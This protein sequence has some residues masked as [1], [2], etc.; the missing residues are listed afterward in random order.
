MSDCAAVAD[1]NVSSFCK[2]YG[3]RRRGRR[4]SGPD[5]ECGYAEGQAFPALVDAVHEKLISE[6]EI[7][8]AL[9]RL[10]NARLRLGMFDPPSSYAFGRIGM[11]ENNTP[12][13]RQLSLKASRESMVLLKNDKGVLP[14]KSSVANIAVIGPTAELVQSLQG[15]YNGPPPNPVYP[16]NGIEKRFKSAHVAYAMG[17]SLGAKGSRCRL[18]TR[19][20]TPRTAA[21]SLVLKANTSRQRT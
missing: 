8:Q 2:G 6:A 21:A 4:Q 11:E 20:C 1:I 9:R 14:L 15:N 5:L 19:L 10:F 7:D 3:A 17:S 12:A 13:H 18:S 16:L